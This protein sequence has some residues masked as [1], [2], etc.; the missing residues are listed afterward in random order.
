MRTLVGGALN[1]RAT[2]P[3]LHG[4]SGF[5]SPEIPSEREK[6]QHCLRWP[7]WSSE[8][9]FEMN[10]LSTFAQRQE[11]IALDFRSNA[12]IFRFYSLMKSG[13]G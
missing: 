6:F 4:E 3:T 5:L 8:N 11:I 7:E 13:V 10:A 12:E 1:A 2:R 9:G